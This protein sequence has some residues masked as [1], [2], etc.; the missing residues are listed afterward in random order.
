MA[1]CGDRRAQLA[2]AARTRTAASARPAPRP[3]VAPAGPT[4]ALT[5]RGPVP[6]VLVGPSTRQVYRMYSVGENIDVDA[7]DVGA[8]VRSG[9]F[10][11]P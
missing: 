10:T 9:W 5:Y 3:V 4:A 1:C 2:R 6:M 11:R 7:R 8:F